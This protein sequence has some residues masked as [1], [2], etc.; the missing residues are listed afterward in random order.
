MPSN[1]PTISYIDEV[2]LRSYVR[3]R[4][5]VCGQTRS[6]CVFFFLLT[7]TYLTLIALMRVDILHLRPLIA[8]FECASSASGCVLVARSKH[9]NVV[10]TPSS[11]RQRG[12]LQ[13]RQADKGGRQPPGLCRSTET[14]TQCARCD[15]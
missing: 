3:R 4:R 9:N 6:V 2:E 13:I 15:I 11:S 14:T 5:V 10:V 7:E 12:A 1:P 8:Q